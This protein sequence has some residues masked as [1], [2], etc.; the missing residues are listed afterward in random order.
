MTASDQTD[1]GEVELRLAAAAWLARMQGPDADVHRPALEQWL[2]ADARHRRIFER[3]SRRFDEAAILQLSHRWQPVPSSAGRPRRSLLWTPG[4][5]IAAGLLALLLSP[6]STEFGHRSAQ[7]AGD[8]IIA[9][10]T[11]RIRTVR[12][13]DGSIVTLDS[14]SSVSI[15]FDGARRWLQLV[16]GRA[17]FQVA[18]ETRPFVVEAG[19]SRVTAHGTLFDVRLSQ[20]GEV[21]VALL[22]GVVDVAVKDAVRTEKNAHVLSAGDAITIRARGTAA[23]GAHV[24][25]ND[26]TWPTGMVDADNVALGQ[27][28]AEANRYAVVPIRIADPSLTSRRLSGHFRIDDPAHLA[29]NLARLLDV[30][31]DRSDPAALWIGRRDKNISGET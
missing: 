12:L 22:E 23:I 14:Q 25:D 2:A 18:H 7:S 26:R 15:R 5:A 10:Q 29:D 27:L 24:V 3:L 16:R 19:L 31:V 13:S 20:R 17:R 21:R 9:A 11:G 6:D 8:A 4:L 1:P 30:S 28:V